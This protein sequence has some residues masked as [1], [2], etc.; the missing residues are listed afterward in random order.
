MEENKITVLIPT[1]N[2]CS[3]LSRA[4]NS[5]LRQTYINLKV[6]ILDN[7][8]NDNTPT[9]CDN[10][11]DNRVKIERSNKDLTMQQNWSRGLALIETKYFL[12]LDD[13]NFYSED[14]VEKILSI[15][16]KNDFAVTY[17]N[18]I[19]INNGKMMSRWKIT[20]E[21]YNL[22]YKQLLKLEFL[23]QTDSNFCLIDFEKVI[24][25]V[26][27]N[28]FYKTI[29][30]D[31]Y[32]IYQLSKYLKNNEIKIGLSTT[33]G[34]YSL[35]GHQNSKVNHEIVNYSS[36]NIFEKNNP[37]DASGNIYLLKIIVLKKFLEI[38]NDQNI[39]KFMN[40]FCNSKYHYSTIAYY[41]HF[42][43]LRQ[44]KSVQNLKILTYYFF[45]NVHY[46]M[47][48]PFKILDGKMAFK[49]MP[50]LVIIFFKKIFLKENSKHVIIKNN[51]LLAD[52]IMN[53]EILIDL[54]KINFNKTFIK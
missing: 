7:N 48:Y 5:V 2:R 17:F 19:T 24:K 32:L 39:K 16:Q 22:N 6:I 23:M 13:D 30:P 18:D 20:N 53:K 27:I 42:F 21:V 15:S 47:K 4:V 37:E 52:K 41:G 46:I 10:I 11:R 38:N 36:L 51:Q 44:T 40:N 28:E 25:L 26:N 8:S 3:M 35:I 33:P 45:K 1:K 12:R 29:L 43:R 31:R 50:I 54:N 9:Y 34:G 49:R 14:F